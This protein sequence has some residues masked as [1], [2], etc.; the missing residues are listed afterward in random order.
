MTAPH[1]PLSIGR[2]AEAACLLE[3]TA[4]KPGNVHPGADFDDLAYVDFLLSAAAIGPVMEDAHRLG[5]GPT[6]AEAIRATRRVTDT[7]TNLGIVLLLAP[8]AAVPPGRTLREGVGDVL[9]GLSVR[10]AEC[11]Y[12]AIRL[13]RPGGLGRADEQDVAAA[14]TVDLRA[15]MRL[16]AGR[17]SVAAQYVEGFVGVFAA[18]GELSA[19][20]A[21]GAGWEDAVIDCHLRWM[22]RRP[23]TLI[24]R[25]CGSQTAAESARRAQSVLSQRRIGAAGA[26]EALR[27]L[28]AWLRGDGRRRNPGTSADLTAATL[29]AALREGTVRL[30][31]RR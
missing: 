22:A 1:A 3:A 13:A 23:D 24:A 8:L 12:E 25:K 11:V 30:P 19:D 18:A 9:A 31:L 20:L 16:A 7:N 10:D 4:R 17:D 5:V 15:A 28:D 27:E 2:C 21:A 14:P 26:A 6:A 29:F